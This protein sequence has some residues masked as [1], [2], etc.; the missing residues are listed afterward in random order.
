MSTF[1]PVPYKFPEQLRFKH[2]A[3]HELFFFPAGNGYPIMGPYIKLSARRYVPVRI[4][5][6][7]LKY[8]PHINGSLAVCHVGSVNAIVSDRIQDLAD[9]HDG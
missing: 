2:L 7:G 5:L 6:R 8:I 1:T 3:R 9:L 4:E